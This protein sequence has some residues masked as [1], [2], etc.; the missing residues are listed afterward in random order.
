MK[1]LTPSARISVDSEFDFR[2]L[3]CCFFSF[4]CLM[5]NS[6]GNVFT[7]KLKRVQT[8]NYQLLL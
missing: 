6:N 2:Q 4:F 3:L 5:K 8:R 7:T 1:M